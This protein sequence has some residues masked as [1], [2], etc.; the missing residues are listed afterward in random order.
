MTKKGS[1]EKIPK[2]VVILQILDNK[3]KFILISQ[4]APKLWTLC[5]ISATPRFNKGEGHCWGRSPRCRWQGGLGAERIF[6]AFT[7]K[8]LVPAHFLIEEEHTDTGRK[9][10]HY[11]S[12]RQYKNILV[13]YV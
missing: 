3:S 4:T 5:A 1:K 9:C 8:K 11:Y 6:T 12:V 2:Y 10:S 13:V 7:Y